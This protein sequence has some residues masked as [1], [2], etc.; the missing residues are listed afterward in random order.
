[1]STAVPRVL[2]VH[3]SPMP[4]RFIATDLALLSEYYPVT[5]LYVQGWHIDPSRTLRDVRRHDLVFAW[6]ASRHSFLPMLFAKLLGKPSALVIGGYDVA[7]MPEIGYGHQRGGAKK[8]V[9]RLTINLATRLLT[10]A[11][12]CREEARRNAGLDDSRITVLHLGLDPRLCRTVRPKEDLVVTVGNVQMDNLARKGMDSFVRAAW[13]LPNVP[14]VLIGPWLDG[15]A[16][17]LLRIAPSNVRI[18]GYL[19]DAELTE[20]MARAKVYVQASIHEGFGLANAE[21]M[22]CGCIPVVTRAG[23]LPEVVGDTG[24]YLSSASEGS[25][26]AG[27]R[28]ALGMSA[29][30]GQRAR[31]RILREF[32]LERRRRLLFQVIDDLAQRGRHG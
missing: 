19:S 28:T 6:F 26:A 23:A 30:W 8:W 27:V 3:N 5:E 32:P 24:V 16:R 18:T 14:F 7:C 21:A 15:A 31:E 10:H 2:F 13:Q 4:M 11:Q 22:L 29:E 20:Y 17:H 1:M 9:S 25:I 12:W